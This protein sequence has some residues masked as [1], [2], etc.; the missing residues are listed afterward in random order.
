MLIRPPVVVSSVNA[1][2]EANADASTDANVA[3][4]SAADAGSVP[5]LRHA[6]TTACLTSDA[7]FAEGGRSAK[8]IL[9]R[10]FRVS[11]V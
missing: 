1:E 7:F 3:R 11:T 4:D 2:A 8:V 5:P 10:T 6:G 9:V